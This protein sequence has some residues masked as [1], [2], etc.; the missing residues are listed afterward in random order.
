MGGGNSILQ[1]RDCG[2][3]RFRSDC[4]Q[5][6]FSCASCSHLL[7]P[8]NADFPDP[9]NTP[10]SRLV[11]GI[12]IAPRSIGLCRISQLY[13]NRNWVRVLRSGALP[14]QFRARG[15]GSL[16]SLG[17]FYAPCTLVASGRL[18]NRCAGR[19]WPLAAL[20]FRILLVD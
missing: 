6:F 20:R 12:R 2:I 4:S 16:S 5:F 9:T 11:K 7:R 1:R 19:S 8:S 13:G 14:Q 10:P 15:H 3:S 17:F 18:I